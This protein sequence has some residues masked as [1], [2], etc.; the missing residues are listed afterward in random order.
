M[1]TY[2]I[3]LTFE[4]PVTFGETPAVGNEVSSLDFI[5]ATA[6]R[7]ALAA[8]LSRQIAPSQ[9]VKRLDTWFGNPGPRWTHGF[10]VMRQQ[11][12]LCVPMPACFVAEKGEPAF[13]FLNT[14]VAD[15]PESVAEYRERFN[16]G[17]PRGYSDDHRFAW[18]RAR[19]RW[20][21]ID[22]DGYPLAHASIPKGNHLHLALHYGRQSH[23]QEQLYSRS[24]IDSAEVVRSF[25]AFVHDPDGAIEPEEQVERV[26][27]GKR[28]SA[29]N[30]AAKLEWRE[31]A[32][33]L[34]PSLPPVGDSALVQLMSDAILTGANGGLQR[35]WGQEEAVASL[36]QDYPG[37]STRW[38]LPRESAVVVSAGSVF[39]IKRDA[40]PSKLGT[41]G[42]GIR[43][44][45]GFGWVA[46][47]PPWLGEPL[48][49]VGEANEWPVG[50]DILDWPGIPIGFDCA[51]S[52]IPRTP[53]EIRGRLRRLNRSAGEVASQL[54]PQHLSALSAYSKR[55]ERPSDVRAFLEKMSARVI[56]RDEE[57]SG[58]GGWKLVRDA[59]SETSIAEARFFLEAAVTYAAQVD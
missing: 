56:S 27:L 45:E 37:W 39:R 20:L 14:A 4:E 58:R 19:S 29:G 46:I 10:P 17:A 28:R 22:Q 38:G 18:Q 53:D 51:P 7:G 40:A 49:E 41:D 6:L 25:R 5:P 3:D 8:A 35:S 9:L 33:P 57:Q 31:A 16:V 30:G 26:Y 42:I 34:W 48:V 52:E 21:S 23:R 24:C 11:Q 50:S 2:Q 32:M 43:R 44:N 59:L 54:S 1:P 36:F 47:D 13:Q 55:V 12:A 15:P